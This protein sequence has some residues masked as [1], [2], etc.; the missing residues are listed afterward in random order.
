[1]NLGPHV[2]TGIVGGIVC[3]IGAWKDNVL[4]LIFGAIL[5]YIGVE[6]VL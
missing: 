4:V 5:I 6:G 3:S 2:L 1:M